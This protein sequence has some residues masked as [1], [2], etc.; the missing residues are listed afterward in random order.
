MLYVF[1]WLPL[2][3]NFLPRAELFYDEFKKKKNKK[4]KKKKKKERNNNNKKSCVD[5][6]FK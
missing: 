4:K 5:D 6:F 3:W 2:A 1:A